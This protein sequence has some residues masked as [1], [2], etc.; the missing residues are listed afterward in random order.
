MTINQGM[1]TSKRDDWETPAALFDQLNRVWRFDLDPCSTDANAKCARHFTAEQDGLA[2][3]WSGRV[4]VNPP[5]GREI[6]KWVAKCDSEERNCEAIVA[7]LP[8]RTDTRWF[9][10][11]VLGRAVVFFMRGRV[12]FETGGV[13]QGPAPFPSM[14][15]IWTRYNDAFR[16]NVKA[17]EDVLWD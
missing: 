6:G 15:A 10:E 9:H 3:A 1:M 7:L 14:V 2:Q 8:A 5:Y 17:M 13:A 11:H 12:R 16:H 4:F